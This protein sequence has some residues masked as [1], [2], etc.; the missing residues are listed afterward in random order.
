MTKIDPVNLQR[1]KPSNWDGPT[2]EGGSL[3]PGGPGRQQGEEE[4]VDGSSLVELIGGIDIGLPG[5]CLPGEDD[6]IED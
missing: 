6:P 2:S 5:S 1:P 3:I 4:E